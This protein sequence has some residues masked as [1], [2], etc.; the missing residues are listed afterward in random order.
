MCWGKC[1]QNKIYEL[2]NNEVKQLLKRCYKNDSQPSLWEISN[3]SSSCEHCKVLLKNITVYRN[4]IVFSALGHQKEETK[5]IYTKSG[6]F[7]WE[8]ASLYLLVSI[9]SVTSF[10][11]NYL[12]HLFI[13]SVSIMCKFALPQ[14]FT[15]SICTFVYVNKSHLY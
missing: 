3:F 11:N 6:C 10:S 2:R 1:I 5:Y 13:V 12:L 8:E 9:F 15:L 4:K 14:T 7:Q